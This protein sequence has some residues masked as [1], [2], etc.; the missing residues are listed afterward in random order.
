MDPECR[1]TRSFAGP[2]L[3]SLS[4]TFSLSF[5]AKGP[6]SLARVR[7]GEEGGRAATV[8]DAP[9]VLRF[10]LPDCRVHCVIR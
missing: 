3:L 9:P 7:I 5:L 10:R 6:S 4:L 1:L 2:L 8:G